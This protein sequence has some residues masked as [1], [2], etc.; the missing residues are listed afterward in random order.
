MNLEKNCFAD[1]CSTIRIGGIAT[2]D[3]HLPIESTSVG[4]LYA[5]TVAKVVSTEDGRTLPPSTPGEIHVKGPVAPV[6]Y[7]NDVAATRDLLTSDGWLRTGDLGLIREDGRVFIVD[8][9][10]VGGLLLPGLPFWSLVPF[11][12]TCVS[13]WKFRQD[14]I[15]VR[16]S[17]VSATELEDLIMTDP[18]VKE[19]AVIGVA[20][21]VCKPL[22]GPQSTL[23]S[24][25][26]APLIESF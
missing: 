10:K 22:R 7:Y 24:T 18:D 4:H 25:R 20:V 1:G 26:V 21:W 6:G 11:P 17:H 8:R 15:K 5:G 3:P 14:L 9:L 12:R 23:T 16:G 19:V 13:C 2:C